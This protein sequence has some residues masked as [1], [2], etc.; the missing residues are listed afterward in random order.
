MT[1]WEREE[2][3]RFKDKQELPSILQA[4][5]KMKANFGVH[6]EGQGLW[7]KVLRHGEQLHSRYA[8]DGENKWH[9]YEYH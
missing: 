1:L 9:E 7:Q 6:I 5:C 3:D 8:S 2:R 4:T